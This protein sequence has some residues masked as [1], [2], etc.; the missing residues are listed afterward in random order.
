VRCIIT[1]APPHFNASSA[2]HT[3]TW[4]RFLGAGLCNLRAALRPEKILPKIFLV[5]TAKIVD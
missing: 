2:Q 4:I 5:K 3:P 1:A